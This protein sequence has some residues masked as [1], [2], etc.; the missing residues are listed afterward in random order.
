MKKLLVLLLLGAL[1]LPNI[2]AAAPPGSLYGEFV[3]GQQVFSFSQGAYKIIVIYIGGTLDGIAIRLLTSPDNIDMPTGYVFLYKD[4]RNAYITWR[5]N[6]VILY[7][8]PVPQ[9]G[10]QVYIGS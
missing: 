4:G 1:L 5:I 8:V 6:G 2:S 7:F 9:N 3:A 10:C